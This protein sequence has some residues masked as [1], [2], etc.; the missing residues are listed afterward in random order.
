MTPE[1]T[2]K[3]WN[4]LS[5]KWV[6]Y[7]IH[8]QEVADVLND[9]G[10][11]SVDPLHMAY[12]LLNADIKNGRCHPWAKC[13]DCGMPFEVGT[14]RGTDFCSEDCENATYEYLAETGAAVYIFPGNEK[15]D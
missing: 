2:A 5:K 12:A 11:Y 3:N 13:K 10:T 4:S 1:E 15:I 8:G 14:G 7:V 9:G 6:D